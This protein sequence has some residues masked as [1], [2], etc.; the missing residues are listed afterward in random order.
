[1]SD[2]ARHSS[3][4]S[5]RI[6]NR[7]PSCANRNKELEVPQSA[8]NKKS[9]DDS[10]YTDQEYL[11]YQRNQL[12]Y[13]IKEL[14]ND[15]KPLRI[16]FKEAEERYNNQ[17]DVDKYFAQHF[18]NSPKADQ[19]IEQREMSEK[20]VHLQQKSD[21]L[22]ERYEKYKILF[23]RVSL[24]QMSTNVYEGRKELFAMREQ[25]R[26]N[27]DKIDSI[28]RQIERVKLATSTEKYRKQEEKIERLRE[29]LT[30]KVRQYED[31]KKELANESLQ[32]SSATADNIRGLQQVLAEKLTQKRNLTNFYNTIVAKQANE[33]YLAS[34]VQQIS[35]KRAPHYNFKSSNYSKYNNNNDASDESFEDTIQ[36]HCVA[37]GLFKRK[38]SE[39]ELRKMYSRY[40]TIRAVEVLPKRNTQPQLYFARVAFSKH[41]DAQNAIDKTNNKKFEGSKIKVKWATDQSLSV[42]RPSFSSQTNG[43]SDQKQ[44]IRI[45]NQS[46][47]EKSKHHHKKALN[48]IDESSDNL[49]RKPNRRSKSVSSTISS[50]SDSS[51]SSPPPKKVHKKK[52]K[53]FR[54]HA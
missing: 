11:K 46:D 17:K 45:K 24:S 6:P 8:R 50:S 9:Y 42:T 49:I 25:S 4:T 32:S 12:L 16:Q 5:K 34:Q 30:Q 19:F 23:S 7:A 37:I 26:E 15:V 10:E 35:A 36:N 40:G 22:Q 13:D 14:L 52:N 44:P 41:D 18:T 31:L 39:N 43:S 29:I 28:H 53:K 51:Y 20:L 27:S 47:K 48:K 21:Q 38:V 2:F 33:E 1:M 54:I 3:K